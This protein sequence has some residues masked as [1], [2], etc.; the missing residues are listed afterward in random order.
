M[1]PL[2]VREYQTFLD[3]SFLHVAR[4]ALRKTTTHTVVGISTVTPNDTFATDRS[5]GSF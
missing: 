4:G 1:T 3:E 5:I 2:L